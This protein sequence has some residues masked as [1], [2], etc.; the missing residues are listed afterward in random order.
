MTTDKSRCIIITAAI[1]ILALAFAVLRIVI[2]VNY[3]DVSE[4]LYTVGAKNVVGI[5]RAV[6][7]CCLAALGVMAFVLTKKRK[8]DELPEASHGVVFTGSLCGFMFISSVVLEIVYFFADV[9][10][11]SGRAVFVLFILSL[12]FAALSSLYYFRAASTTFMKKLNYRVF[13]IMPPLW[14]ACYAV[15]IYFSKNTVINSPERL[16]IQ[17]SVIMIMLYTVSEARFHFGI[18]RPRLHVALSAV[19][20]VVIITACV[21][22]FL[23]TAFWLLPFSSDTV[24]SVL[25]VGVAMYVLQRMISV[26]NAKPV[27]E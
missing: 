3:Y 9:K 15:T 6:F 12:L 10:N 26:I 21:P 4:S 1:V 2:A 17:L 14:A 25:Q 7:V 19:T 13:C 27:E 8:F 22:N 5:V 20:V 18:A 16:I 11:S 24:F 23:L